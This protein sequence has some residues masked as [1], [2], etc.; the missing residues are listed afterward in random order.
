M[1][2]PIFDSHLDL[3]W[4]AVSFNRDLTLDV[5]EIRR[6]E[7]GMTDA[8]A[9]GHNTV[10]LPELR[11]AGVRICVGT[12]LARGGP[13][14]KF[15][16]SYKRV[17][18]DHANQSIAYAAAHAQLAYYR[19]LETQGHV[20]I[21]RSRDDMDAHWQLGQNPSGQIPLGIILSMEGTD[22]IVSPDQAQEWWDAGLRAAGP[23]HYGRS[24]YAYGTG[25]LGPLSK[26]GIEL[27]E[28]FQRL[29]MILDVTHLCDQSMEQA[30]NL[31]DGPI[32]ASH[33]NCRALVPGDRQLTDAQ[34]LRLIAR[35]AVIGAAL[36][37]WMLYPGWE[38]GLTTPEVVGLSA[39]ADHIDHVCQLAGDAKH[40]G[41][42]SDLDGGFG[43]E[44]TPH[45][46]NTIADLQKLGDILV[47]RNYS[48]AEIDLIFHG[49]WLR[50]FGTSLP[51]GNCDP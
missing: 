17:D 30:L 51:D 20:R 24:H 45:D 40:A 6:R 27:L 12:L 16:D 42:G 23:A 50:F 13:E 37:A 36:D 34:I 29:G 4:S 3:A 44:Q 38:R 11:T 31:Y 41:I 35:D 9:R 25:V 19:L 49:N 47:R 7:Q 15:Q 26:M 28:Q 18:L 10:S 5:H 39:V 46:L 43:Y 22:P 8:R 1:T 33:H 21:L 48:N 14:Q 2:R 32:L